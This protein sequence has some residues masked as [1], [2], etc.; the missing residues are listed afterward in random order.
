ATVWPAGMPTLR[1]TPAL[2]LHSRCRVT[3]ANKPQTQAAE[4]NHQRKKMIFANL[5]FDFRPLQYTVQFSGKIQNGRV[6]S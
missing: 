1:S 6:S 5:P 4:V 2:R 3:S